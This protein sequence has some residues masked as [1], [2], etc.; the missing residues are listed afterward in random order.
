MRLRSH[1]PPPFSGEALP[2]RA[3][4]NR[5]A[6]RSWL[7]LLLIL[8]LLSACNAVDLIEARIEESRNPRTVYAGHANLASRVAWLPDGRLISAGWDE[9]AI[10]WGSDGQPALTLQAEEVA[11]LSALALHPDGA[12]VLTGDSSGQLALWNLTS[13]TLSATLPAHTAA[14][15]GVAFS[16]DGRLI[17]SGA[18]DGSLSIRDAGVG[19]EIVAMNQPGEG[20]QVYSLAW[21]PDG[22][23]IASGGI[24]GQVALWDAAGALLRVIGTPAD[25]VYGLAFSPDGSTL[26]VASDYLWIILYDLATGAQIATL[27]GAEDWNFSV[28]FSPDGTRIASGGK[29]SRILIHDLATGEVIRTLLGHAEIV[30]ALAWAPDAQSLA[31]AAS[32]GGIIVWDLSSGPGR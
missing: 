20:A 16:P 11:S 27:G 3:T 8:P 13:G 32:D 18:Q 24:D 15:S 7:L 31:S 21:S 23:S 25:Y 1:I 28:A 2:H 14:V 30:T 6:G 29:D 12:Q 9:Q 4:S 5:L 22:T 10:V 26:A 19:R 17:A